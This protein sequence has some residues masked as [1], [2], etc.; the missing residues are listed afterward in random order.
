MGVAARFVLAGLFTILIA[1]PVFAEPLALEVADASVGFD[2]RTNEP[3]INVFLKPATTTV[4][5]QFT[6]EN[7]GRKV[8]IRIDGKSVVKPF[9]RE[10]ILGGTIQI[11]GVFTADQ[12]REIAKRLSSGNSK[13]EVETAKD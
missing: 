6:R 10:P 5:S 3:I 11:S 13:I 1:C 12:A 7:V 2:Q 8:E 4:F 9:I